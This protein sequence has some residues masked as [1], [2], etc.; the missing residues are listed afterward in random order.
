MKT[1]YY[2]NVVF[3]TQFL[4]HTILKHSAYITFREVVLMSN[5]EGEDKINV[6]F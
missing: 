5:Q 1:R 6:T 3:F 4:S 2:L